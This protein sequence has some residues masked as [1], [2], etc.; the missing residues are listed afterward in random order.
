MSKREKTSDELIAEL[1]LRRQ[2]ASAAKKVHRDKTADIGSCERMMTDSDYPEP[3]YQAFLKQQEVCDACKA[4]QPLWKDYKHKANLAG[5]V[6]RTLLSR[7]KHMVEG[8]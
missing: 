8:L 6:L 4:K 7:G 3:C 2:A 5:G 1:Y